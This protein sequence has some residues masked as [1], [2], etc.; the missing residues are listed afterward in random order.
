MFCMLKKK[1]FIL[2]MFQNTTQIVKIKSFLMI[3]KGWKC[4]YLAVR[5]IPALLRGI[6]W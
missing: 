5:E 1:N 4:H 3:P 2:P 6:T